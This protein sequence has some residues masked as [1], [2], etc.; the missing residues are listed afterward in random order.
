MIII[1]CYSVIG[2]SWRGREAGDAPIGT[3][4]YDVVDD[5]GGR[6]G[7]AANAIAVP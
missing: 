7:I 6:G 4:C 1:L 2:D 3:L 5:D